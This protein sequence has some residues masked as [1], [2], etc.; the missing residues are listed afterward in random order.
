[1]K[2]RE[3]LEQLRGLLDR[4]ERMPASADRDWMIAEVRARAVDVETGVPPA[5]LRALPQSEL[6]VELAPAPP[7]RAKP[8]RVRVSRAKPVSRRPV[9]ASAV[10]PVRAG[11]ETVADVVD[12]L[13]QDGVMSL[14]ELPAVMTRPWAA[15][16]RG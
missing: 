12:L 5:P 8:V 13:E 11:S 7:A 14:D 6:D 2:D 1:M 3:R 15:G 4:L 10:A 16:L 9:P